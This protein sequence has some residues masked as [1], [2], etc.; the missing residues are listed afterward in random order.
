MFYFTLFT[1]PIGR[2]GT[3]DVATQLGAG[4]IRMR[5]QPDLLARALEFR[6]VQ[7]HFR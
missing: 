4:R 7:V 2:T 5:E 1:F 6:G 3:D